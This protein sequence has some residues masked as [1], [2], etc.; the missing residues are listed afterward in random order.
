M[1]KKGREGRVPDT[2]T[3]DDRSVLA[4]RHS[5]AS[6]DESVAPEQKSWWEQIPKWEWKSKD[7][8]SV[9]P[10][11]KSWW[12]QIP[13]WEQ[14]VKSEQSVKYE[15]NVKSEQSVETK[16]RIKRERN[17]IPERTMA[18]NQTAL[19]QPS[20]T[21]TASDV[22]IVTGWVVEDLGDGRL[23]VQCAAGND[24][25]VESHQPVIYVIKRN[26]SAIPKYE[27]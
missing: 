7:E 16:P 6:R 22:N 20:I 11:Q 12:E 24:N 2:A 26:P 23:L 25:F 1:E 13:K 4:S 17:P 27:D 10:E 8:Q 15:E 9:A 21:A 5:T 14:S 3:S 19:P 18:P